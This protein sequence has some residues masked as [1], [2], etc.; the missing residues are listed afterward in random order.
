MFKIIAVVRD[1]LVVLALVAGPPAGLLA[2]AGSPIPDQLPSATALQGWV[3]DPLQPPLAAVTATTL[4]W[5]LWAAY[6]AAIVASLTARLRV[7]PRWRRLYAG[8]P[9]PMHGLAATLLGAAAVTSATAPAATAATAAPTADSPGV[10]DRAVRSDG[11]AVAPSRSGSVAAGGDDRAGAGGQQ[12]P[13]TA[14]DRAASHPVRR[15]DTLS[16]IA[17]R[18]LGDADRW[19]EIFAL[20]RGTRFPAGGTLTDPDLIY[21]RWVLKLPTGSP[22]QPSAHP[23]AIPGSDAEDPDDQPGPAAATTGPTRATPTGPASGAAAPPPSGSTRPHPDRPAPPESAPA[24]AA[25]HAT[26]TGATANPAQAHPRR[27]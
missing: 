27:A 6:T 9:S 3:D 8:L 2:V 14:P 7:R 15:G 1:T 17:E 11:D 24:P 19:P 25:A 23:P 22:T 12:P 16:S 20:N 26:A 21:P 13:R 10:P 18:H 4:G 5:L